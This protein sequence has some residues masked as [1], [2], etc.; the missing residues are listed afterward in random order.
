MTTET[1]TEGPAPVDASAP[2]LRKGP[3]RLLVVTVIVLIMAAS[4][5]VG[6][7][8]AGGDDGA[9]PDGAAVVVQEFAIPP[10]SFQRVAAGEDVEVIPAELH[11]S[12]GDTIRI[13]NEDTVGQ[14]VGPY[15]VPAGQ[16]V[17]QTFDEDATYE[18]ICTAHKDGRIRIVVGT[19]GGSGTGAGA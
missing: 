5:L 11:L 6:L 19:G 16:S 4:I 2:E 17:Q 9:G 15:Y 1:P 8:V 12:V 7:L 14:T 3:P 13:R 10:G 18:G